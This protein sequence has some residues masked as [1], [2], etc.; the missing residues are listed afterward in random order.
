MSYPIPLG[1]YIDDQSTPLLFHVLSVGEGLM[2][3]VVF[4][5]KTTFLYDCNVTNDNEE[6]I[7]RYL[8]RNLPLRYDNE[9]QQDAQWIDVFVNSHRDGDHYRGLSKVHTQFKIK[10][11]WDSGET[12][13]STKSP[14]Y[15]YYM[16][17]RRRLRQ[18]YG[19]DAVIIPAPSQTPVKTFGGAEIYCLNSSIEYNAEAKQSFVSFSRYESSLSGIHMLEAARVQHTNSIVL[20]LQYAERSILLTSD[21]DWKAWRDKIVPNFEESG[22]LKSEVLLAS[23]HGSRSFFTDE[24]ENEHIE[25][26]ANPETTYTDSLEYIDPSITLISCGDYNSPS[27]HPNKEAEELY[28]EHTSNEQVYTT[29]NKG[30]M[31]GFIDE[32]GNW[33]VV[34]TR[35][36]PGASHHRSFHIKCTC[37]YQDKEY[38]ADSDDNFPIESDL[39]FSIAPTRL[40]ESPQD[41]DIKWEVSNGG[42][43]EDSGHQ[44]IYFKGK[45]E[46]ERMTSFCRKVA[47][48]GKHLLRCKVNN[49]K[50]KMQATQ[51]FIVNGV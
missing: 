16:G 5:D 32:C 46:E 45:N 28:K 12:G 23:H 8:E 33:T 11:I 38:E 48:E 15:N 41:V 37:T 42:I 18:K 3:L 7:L 49:K 36:F 31:A 21:S 17:L 35:F 44:E 51:I 26:E 30:T 29:Y 50:K 6:Q 20:S 25:P 10:S 1:Y 13:A 43:N 22:L 47:Y 14:D 27:H 2:F 9:T 4:P 40:L 24:R 34:P 19:E 39:H